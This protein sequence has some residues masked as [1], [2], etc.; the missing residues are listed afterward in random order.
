[1]PQKKAVRATR[2]RTF[3][4]G[5]SRELQELRI[6]IS[7]QL[8]VALGLPIACSHV[9]PAGAMSGGPGSVKVVWSGLVIGRARHSQRTHQLRVFRPLLEEPF[10]RPLV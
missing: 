4:F 5:V 3:F 7:S 8:N 6:V 10:R 2:L 9:Q 1:M